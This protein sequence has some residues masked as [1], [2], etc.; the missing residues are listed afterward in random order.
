[1]HEQR[2]TQRLLQ[3][4]EMI[5]KDN[6]FPEMAHFNAA[7]LEEIWPY[8]FK[9]RADRMAKLAFTYEYMGKPIA[10]LYG[11]DLVGKTV[12]YSMTQFPGGVIHKKLPEVLE[13]SSILYDAGHFVSQDGSLIKYRACLLPFGKAAQGVT[14]IV[15][16]LSCRKF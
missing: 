13:K 1:M 5:R 8:C 12:D 4:W 6:P 3:Y 16:G 14:H 11:H 10:E 2:L 15:V 7:A 9:V